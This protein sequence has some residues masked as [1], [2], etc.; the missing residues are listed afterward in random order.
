MK[1]KTKS[2]GKSILEFEE[3]YS[4]HLS[5]TVDAV[6]ALAKE[7]GARRTAYNMWEFKDKK[8]AEEFIFLYRLKYE[9]KS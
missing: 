2:N 6:V 4:I 7:Q 5:E 8:S 1:I 3:F 9:N